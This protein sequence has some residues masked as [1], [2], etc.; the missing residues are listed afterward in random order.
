MLP[1]SPPEAP[2]SD[3]CPLPALPTDR[4]AEITSA[5]NLRRGARRVSRAS[6][7]LTSFWRVV[8]DPGIPVATKAHDIRHRPRS[9]RAAAG[10]DH[11]LGSRHR[12]HAVSAWPP[13]RRQ[14]RFRPPPRALHSYFFGF[15]WPS[16]PKTP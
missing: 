5:A 3:S 16:V 13:F 2:G 11:G 6:P 15:F 14:T 1:E 8:G 7:L 12:C 4:H 10:A 9:H